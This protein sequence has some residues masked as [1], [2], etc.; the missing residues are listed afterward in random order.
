M[1]ADLEPVAFPI[2][3]I[4]D[5]EVRL[6]LRADS[7]LPA[8]VEACQ[9]PGI[10]AYTRAPD[11]Y[12]MNDAEEF[13]RRVDRET[14][15]GRGLSLIIA[16][17]ADD[18]LL[19]TIGFFD[20][21]AE[22]GRLELGYWLAPWARG[23]GLMTRALRLFCGWIFAELDVYRIQAGIEPDNAPSLALV[24][25]A[26]FTREG[27]LRSLFPMKGRRRDVISCSLLRGELPTASD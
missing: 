6:R 12:E 21:S 19:G 18:S 14:D 5:G 20:Y 23:R 25:R 17:I 13:A 16:D 27:T 3:G 24:E 1:S 2:G 11:D 26:G 4:D 9:D 8:I 10:Q 7:D 15:S 22:E